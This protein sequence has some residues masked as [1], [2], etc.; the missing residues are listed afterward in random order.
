MMILK[1]GGS[2]LTDKRK[3]RSLRE[4]DLKRIGK[5]IAEGAQAIKGGLVIVHG[6]GSFGHPLA[7]KYDLVVTVPTLEFDNS[8]YSTHLS[9]AANHSRC[10]CGGP[11]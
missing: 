1:L 3:E 5:E 7:S 9:L 8:P 4:E 2:L 10:S 6:G 11:P